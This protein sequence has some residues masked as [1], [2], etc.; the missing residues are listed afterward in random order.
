ML[1]SLSKS[2]RPLS[3]ILLAAIPFWA[4]GCKTVET[5][6]VTARPVAEAV[7]TF[8]DLGP[9]PQAKADYRLPASVILCGEPLP[10]ERPSVREKLEYEFLMAVNHPAQ[11]E[12]WR[13]RAKRFFPLIEKS[14]KAAGLPD[15]LK[16]LAVAESD[17]RPV[18][19]SPAG[20]SGL[21]QFMPAT[22]RRFGIP[23]N[24]D[25]DQR[26]L[27]ELLLGAGM[28][29]LSMLKD[30]FGSWSLAMAA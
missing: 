7:T 1:S 18:V 9:P 12:L 20:A 25:Q 2:I 10:M 19:S 15:D 22:A 3:I 6:D 16:Y 14:L 8:M 17:L 11:V 30:R 5:V 29:Y 4:A 23:V 27:P 21:W 13:R 28:K 24:K 26:L